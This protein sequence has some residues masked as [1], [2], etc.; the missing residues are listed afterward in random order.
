MGCET[1]AEH[2]PGL[3]QT[4][5][6]H[7]ECKALCDSSPDCVAV[8]MLVNNFC[9]VFSKFCE[10]PFEIGMDV[11]AHYTRL[12]RPQSDP[13]TV[14]PDDSSVATHITAKLTTPVPTS[15]TTVAPTTTSTDPSTTTTSGV[16][17]D[18][19]TTRTQSFRQAIDTDA[20][21]SH[22]WTMAIVCSF[23][24]LFV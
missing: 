4:V 12:K 17:G 13:A 16:T 3:S 14:A 5:N 20:S 22:T 9:R 23:I 7:V 24:M 21:N 8:S 19:A 11:A 15:T 1:G 18:T 6:T 2:V 10:N